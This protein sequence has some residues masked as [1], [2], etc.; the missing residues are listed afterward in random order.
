MTSNSST[1]ANSGAAR[2]I[3]RRI[4][5]V[6]VLAVLGV[7]VV[8]DL[9]FYVVAVSPLDAREQE[10][11]A[12]IEILKQQV[13]QKTK[14]LEELRIIAGKVE[15]ARTAG[16]ELLDQITI[17]RRVTFSTLVTE[18]NSAAAEAGI[19]DRDRVYDMEPIDGTEVYGI[20]SINANFRGEY[21]KLVNF[22]HRIDRSE[23]FLIIE[24]LGASP[25]SDSSE[26]QVTMRIDT[27]VRDL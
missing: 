27:F 26:L 25:R 24:S 9:L 1:T 21:E 6:H 16:D 19:Q 4:T 15:K 17:E 22:L 20:V 3:F 8:F 18:L 23:R 2:S 13:E 7:L 5:R 12:R 10:M 14:G 11:L